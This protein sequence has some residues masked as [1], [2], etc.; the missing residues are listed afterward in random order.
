MQRE[1]ATGMSVGWLR[2][3]T[4]ESLR[5]AITVCAPE[6]ATLPISARAPKAAPCEL[7]MTRFAGQSDY[8]A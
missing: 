1:T 8:A 2:D 5:S 6:L 3:G 7:G 4:E